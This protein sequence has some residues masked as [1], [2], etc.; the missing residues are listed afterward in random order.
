ME[1]TISNLC[2][3]LAYFCNHVDNSCEA[4]K[5]SVQRRPI[6]LDSAS[7]T[8]IQCLNRRVST[9][10]SDLNLLDSMS[11]GTVSFEELLGHCNEV[12]KT[13]QTHLLQL[14]DRLK[15]FNNIPE[16]KIDDEDEGCS[17]STPFGLDSKDE[18]ESS[19]PISF[20]RS[21]MK[22]L[23]EDTLLDESL[24]LKNL[25]L[26]DVCLATL[27]S[28]VDNDSTDDQDMCFQEPMKCYGDKLHE[29]KDPSHH[30][31]KME[32]ELKDEP[33]SFEATGPVIKVS[34]DDYDSIPSYMKTL[35]SWEDLLVAV[36]KINSKMR[37]EKTKGCDYFQQDEIASLDLGHKARAYLLL[38]TR[39]NLLRVETIDGRISYRV[40]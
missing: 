39:L 20:S 4:L 30:T 8:F 28:E 33:M 5:Q 24:S 12:Y 29:I 25:G 19:S 34:K 16:F 38:L 35:T 15:T 23:E 32:G 2:K 21:V 37:K 22:S 1:E 40:L 31:M 7:S 9:V 26:S 13:N 36:E 17:L 11:F 27:A 18:M 10:T 14:H 3:T 6:P